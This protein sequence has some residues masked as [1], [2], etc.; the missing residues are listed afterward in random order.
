MRKLK[1]FGDYL[2]YSAVCLGC[3]NWDFETFAAQSADIDQGQNGTVALPISPVEWVNGNVNAVITVPAALAMGAGFFIAR[4]IF[5]QAFR[6]SP[7]KG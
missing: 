2:L 3:L 5:A 7:A 6:K 1:F 4:Q